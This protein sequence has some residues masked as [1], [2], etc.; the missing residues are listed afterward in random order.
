MLVKSKKKKT[1]DD[2][3]SFKLLNN[4]LP[5]NSFPRTVLHIGQIRWYQHSLLFCI[6]PSCHK[7]DRVKEQAKHEEGQKLSMYGIWEEKHNL[8][9]IASRESNPDSSVFEWNSTRLN[10]WYFIRSSHKNMDR[11]MKIN[12][13]ITFRRYTVRVVRRGRERERV[14]NIIC[15][16]LVVLIFL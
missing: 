10:F 6:L 2:I 7:E 4:V 13:H 3:T 8:K 9:I 16:T 12:S 5:E 1:I 14:M 15:V 11:I